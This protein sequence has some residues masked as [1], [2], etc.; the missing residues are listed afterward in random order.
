MV[1]KNA[2]PSAEKKQK[3]EE[4]AC[5][6]GDWIQDRELVLKGGSTGQ[7]GKET[8]KSSLD[9]PCHVNWFQV[10]T[11]KSRKGVRLCR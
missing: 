2:S 3:K 1:K 9:E 4:A 7:G 6:K 5:R 11:P 8:I 10:G